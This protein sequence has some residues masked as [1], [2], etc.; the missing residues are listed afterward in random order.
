MRS[1]QDRQ[2]TQDPAIRGFNELID[3]MSFRFDSATA[4]KYN[5][6]EPSV[7]RR[8]AAGVLNL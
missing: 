6:L 2:A 7:N 1:T 3:F 5:C 8:Y 4:L